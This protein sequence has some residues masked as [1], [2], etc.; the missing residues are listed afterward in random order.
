MFARSVSIRLKPNRVAEF[1]QLIEAEVLALL[2]TQK[3]FLDEITLVLPEGLQA[4]GISLWDNQQDANAY[5]RG[6]Y[7]QVL[8][9][10]ER[11][12]GGTPEVHTFEVAHSTFHKIGA[13]VAA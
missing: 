2:R 7:P 8:K 5:R 3:G 11:V 12:V 1:T 10:L 13:R 6:A 4:V 9:V